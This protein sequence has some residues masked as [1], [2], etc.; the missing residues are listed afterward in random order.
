MVSTTRRCGTGASS[1][2]SSRWPGAW[3]G[4]WDR[5]SG[6]YTRTRADTR[7]CTRCSACA[8]TRGRARRRRGTCRPPARPR[9]ATSRTRARSAHRRRSAGTADDPT[10]PKQRRCL[11]ASGL[12]DAMRHRCHIGHARSR[13]RERRAYVRLGCWPSPFRCATGH[14]DA[15]SV[16]RGLTMLAVAERTD[17]PRSAK[18]R[19]VRSQ[20]KPALDPL[21]T[22]S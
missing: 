1:V 7:A 8:R 6:I 13:T 15:T 17:H 4:S 11:R 10:Q 20:Q 21:Y 22:H 12:V 18:P 9:G 3:R 14:S 19:A 2:V 16:W 5:S